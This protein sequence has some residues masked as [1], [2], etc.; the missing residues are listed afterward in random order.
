[1]IPAL[2]R[3][4]AADA[5]AY[6]APGP[7]SS[8]DGLVAAINLRAAAE[9]G[10]GRPDSARAALA[11]LPQGADAGGVTLHNSALLATDNTK[12]TLR[13]LSQLLAA[14]EDMSLALQ[15]ALEPAL[16]N[17]L[18]ALLGA[19]ELDRAAKILAESEA[20]VGS[21]R[22]P[23][24]L[25]DFVGAAAARRGVPDQALSVLGALAA[26]HEATLRRR[27]RGV[28]DARAA[29]GPDRERA[30]LVEYEAALDM[31][32]AGR[33]GE[34]AAVYGQLVAAN[35]GHVL[36]APPS[37]AAGLA[38]AY[39]LAGANDAAEA[40]LVRCEA[41]EAAAA[42]DWAGA[43]AP[44]PHLC[45][46]NL[47]LG[48]LYCVKGNWEFGVARVMSALRPLERRLTRAT[49][50]LARRCLLA[51]AE[52]AAKHAV[53]MSVMPLPSPIAGLP[54]AS[55]CVPIRPGPQLGVHDQAGIAWAA[56]DIGLPGAPRM[57]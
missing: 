32:L 35:G 47:A 15:T 27:A 49:W 9:L 33:S 39:V 4:E 36:A 8:R 1:M 10:L 28:Q 11:D 25:A 7:D 5:A 30:E 55:R 45:A 3:P 19:G 56:Y 12:A 38:V 57:R 31:Y 43:G 14:H 20:L 46:V 18:L 26:R 13:A 44:Q 24:D 53:F 54:Y 40:L 37:V 23:Q 2:R 21:E 51:L 16:G 48:M 50:P 52:Q 22:L 29:A 34:A 6:E 17:L 41:E 42:D